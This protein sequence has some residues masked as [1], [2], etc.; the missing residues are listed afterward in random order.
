[1]DP[2][3]KV[4]QGYSQGVSQAA[5]SS[6]GLT[7]GRIGSQTHSGCWQ[8]SFLSNCRT[9]VPIFIPAFSQELLATS[10]SG[11]CHVAFSIVH[12]VSVRFFKASRGPSLFRKDAVL[13][14]ASAD[15]VRRFRI[16]SL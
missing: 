11:V 2:L 7:G 8:D 12:N 15:D 14:T 3:L 4:L 5:F 9:E 6:G 10:S 1:M 13:L 16:I